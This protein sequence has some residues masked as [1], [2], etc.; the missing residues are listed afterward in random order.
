MDFVIL[1]V[2][3]HDHGWYLY[4]D[5]DCLH[6]V[7]FGENF[8]MVF[9]I[10]LVYVS[11]PLLFPSTIGDQNSDTTHASVMSREDAKSNASS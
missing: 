2:A 5:I 10:S 6:V 1:A 3:S 9:E 11:L 4:H 8:W 7:V